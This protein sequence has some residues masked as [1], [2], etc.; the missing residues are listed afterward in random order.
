[1]ALTA[2]ATFFLPPGSSISAG[3]PAVAPSARSGEAG[4][5]SQSVRPVARVN[6][7]P[8]ALEGF[9]DWIVR[10]HGWR[11]VD[12][13]VTLVLLKQ[14][15]A[16]MGLEPPTEEE[17]A[18]AFEADWHDQ[19]LWR[20]RG[21]EASFEKELAE[22]GLDRQGWRDRRLGTLE[23]EVVAR[24]ILRARPPTD[25]QKS[26]LWRRDFGPDGQRVHVRVAFF[27]KLAELRPGVEANQETLEAGDNRASAAAKRFHRAV[28]TD[29]ARFSELVRTESDLCTVL[30][31]DNM[32]VD[33]RARGGE[34]P[35]LGSGHFG[36]A[37]RQPLAKAAVGDL[38]GP[39]ATP[40]GYYV[41]EL[42]ARAAAPF[43]AVQDELL[44]IW[45]TRDPSQG[46]IYFL[47]EELR[48]AARIERFPLNPPAGG[49]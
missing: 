18:A 22:S 8:L 46:E 44:E 9:R 33:L 19:V 34:L 1:M 24:R 40:Q 23:Q 17:I 21:E 7:E 30:R 39:I 14:E 12:D 29:R 28:A 20:H 49:P 3:A 6:G 43:E 10:T 45:R 37:L 15:T 47:K 11:H 48:K 31:H 25:A 27:D 16:R 4:E 32:P 2:I 38:V 13:Y 36:D 5:G 26:E 41:V 35:R 42:V